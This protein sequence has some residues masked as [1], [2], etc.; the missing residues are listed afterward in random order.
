MG[1][2]SDMNEHVSFA[3]TP[4]GDDYETDFYA[5]TRRQAE[6]L[7]A[8]Q[9]NKADVENLAEEVESLGN[10]DRNAVISHMAVVIEHLLKLTVSSDHDPRNG[11][12]RSVV[13]AR[14]KIELIFKASPSLGARRVELYDQAW[15]YGFR[16]A[17]VGVR[18]DEAERLGTTARSQV[19]TVDEALDPDFFPEG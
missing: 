10:S 16:L 9:L 2:A 1:Y 8:H 19:F 17:A 12:K 3:A 4:G 6:L 11:W 7:R 14:G 18:Q 13:N 5:W 15:T